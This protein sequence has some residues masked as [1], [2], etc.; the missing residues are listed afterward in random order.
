MTQLRDCRAH[1]VL[2]SGQLA[3]D[4]D[5]SGHLPLLGTPLTGHCAAVR[6]GN[7]GADERQEGSLRCVSAH[8][9]TGRSATR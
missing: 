4:L 2:D 3:G 7:S 1:V 5:G 9:G 8:L 6:W